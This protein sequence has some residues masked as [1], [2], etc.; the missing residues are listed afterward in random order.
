MIISYPGNVLLHL[1]RDP[2]WMPQVNDIACFASVASVCSSLLLTARYVVVVA[3]NLTLLYA[4]RP[5]IVIVRQ[6]WI[7]ISNF[8]GSELFIP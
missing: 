2:R 4:F 7:S 8:R 1:M 3:V 6:Y 5:P